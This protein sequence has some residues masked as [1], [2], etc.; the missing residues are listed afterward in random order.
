VAFLLNSP[1]GESLDV[2]NKFHPLVPVAVHGTAFKFTSSFFMIKWQS[3][4]FLVCNMM[5]NHVSWRWGSRYLLQAV[6]LASTCSED[7]FLA[8]FLSV[9]E[10]DL[11]DE[12]ADH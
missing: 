6:A 5:A 8:S 7:V 2:L 10:H 9:P 1:S 3:M 4:L 12:A 11:Q